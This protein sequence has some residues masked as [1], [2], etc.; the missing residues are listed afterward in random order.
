MSDEAVSDAAVSGPALSVNLMPHAPVGRIAEL[1]RFAEQLRCR[2]VW[3]YDEGIGGRDVW[4]TLAAVAGATERVL[5]GPGITNPYI[6]HPG[7]TAT[8]VSGLDELSGGRAF[9]GLGSGGALALEPL[10]IERTRPLT[11]LDETVACLRELFAGAT[12]DFDGSHVRFHRA[13]LAYARPGIEILL[14]G[15][16]P[17]LIELAARTAD[18]FYL[19]YVHKDTI[20]DTVATLRSGGRP[21]RISYSTAI[22]IDDDD[23][24]SAR[25]DLSF[26]L[27]DS[28]ADVRRRIGFSDAHAAAIR[29]ALAEGGPPAAARHVDP[30][31]VPHFALVGDKASVAA[32]LRALMAEHRIDE[33]L[34]AVGDLDSAEELIERTAGFFGET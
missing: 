17:R 20:A 33:F 21:F 12:L 14:A 7:A 29:A 5:I 1:A 34:L 3:V 24:D 6:R 4:V 31:W 8:A 11:A 9:L 18:G 27:L 19:S 25:A 23:M 2:R 13:R 15:R 16:G 32:E 26:R 30:D 22:V 10:G 28:P